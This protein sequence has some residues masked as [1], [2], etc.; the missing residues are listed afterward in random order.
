[1]GGKTFGGMGV[2]A[3]QN[4]GGQDPTFRAPELRIGHMGGPGHEIWGFQDANS[5]EET[6]F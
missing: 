3:P 4:L 5:R 1:M 6:S 2:S